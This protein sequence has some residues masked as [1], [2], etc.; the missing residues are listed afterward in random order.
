M[1]AFVRGFAVLRNEKQLAAQ[2]LRVAR[3]NNEQKQATLLQQKLL[4]E[5]T[6]FQQA[7]HCMDISQAMRYFRAAHVGQNKNCTTITLNMRILAGKGKS[8]KQKISGTLRFPVQLKESNVWV[9]TSDPVQHEAAIKAGATKVGGI[10]LLNVFRDLE[11]ASSSS[12]ARSADEANVAA[13]VDNESKA[14]DAASGEGVFEKVECDRIIT[15]PEMASRF[16]Q[17]ARILGPRGLMPSPK[18][19]TV[20]TEVADAVL[21]ARSQVN[22]KQDKDI[23]CIPVANV[24]FSDTEIVENILYAVGTLRETMTGTIGRSILHS[25]GGPHIAV[26]V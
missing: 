23:V 25:C 16:K 11:A 3:R 17:F 4:K 24:S 26:I 2:K 8:A 18:R 7:P 19:G 14:A 10:E 1:R 5:Q 13:N 9:I 22:Y 21:E 20:V 12:S 15:T 6:A